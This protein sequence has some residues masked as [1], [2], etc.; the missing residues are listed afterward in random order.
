MCFSLEYSM[1]NTSNSFYA[2][3]V[4]TQLLICVVMWELINGDCFLG[5]HWV[6]LWAADQQFGSYG[7]ADGHTTVLGKSFS[8]STM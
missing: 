3:T 4:V 8:A 6:W 2:L 1:V 7:D 5:E